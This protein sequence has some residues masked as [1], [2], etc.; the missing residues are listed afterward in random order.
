[1]TK[2]LI[3][4]TPG[5]V[6]YGTGDYY[7]EIL[8][9]LFLPVV[10][11]TVIYPNTRLKRL[12]R[13]SQRVRGKNVVFPIHKDDANGV[14]ALGA[15]ATLPEPDTEKFDQ[16]TFGIRHIYGRMKFD[17]ITADAN[18]GAIASWLDV[19]M[20]EMQSKAKLLARQR[21]RMYCNDGSGVL[22][23]VTAAGGLDPEVLTVRCNQLIESPGTITDTAPTRWIKVGQIIC[24]IN[25][26]S[27]GPTN[28]P[29]GLGVV[30]SKTATTITLEDPTVLTGERN[31]I[32]SFVAGDYIVSLS[33]YADDVNDIKIGKETGFKNEPMGIRGI[34]QDT[35]PTHDTYFQGIDSSGT[36]NPFNRAT[37]LSNGGVA[38]PITIDLLDEAVMTVVETADSVPTAIFG[39]FKQIRKVAALILPERRFNTTGGTI[40]FEL[41]YGDLTIHG[42]PF[43]ADRDTY[44]NSLEFVDET[45]LKMYVM[46]DMTWMDKD[47]SIYQRM[48]D[49]DEYQATFY[50]RETLGCDVR[51]KHLLITDLS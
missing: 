5:G 9:D 32:G 19:V 42:I 31:E 17:G 2:T 27:S 43:F 46:K 48:L 14:V 51:D 29:R 20:N 6:V 1:M 35:N 30:K 49:K 33:H 26:G 37:I 21:Q 38:R 34:L 16:Y 23:E 13:T 25:P 10:A 18:E 12:P 11:D 22:C 8:Q 36:N 3:D 39:D 7:T 45:D 4:T 15:G 28:S 40:D 50:C 24:G 41:G 47:G 44:G